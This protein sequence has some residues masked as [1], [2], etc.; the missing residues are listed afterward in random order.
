MSGKFLIN[1]KRKKLHK[2]NCYIIQNAGEGFKTFQSLGSALA[3]FQKP[4][5]ACK[6]CLKKD[7]EVQKM[8]DQHNKSYK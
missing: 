6:R 8:V 2:E 7:E 4:L 5:K 1:E 3:N